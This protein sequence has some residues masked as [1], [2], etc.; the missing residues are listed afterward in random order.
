MVLAPVVSD[1][2]LPAPAA[3]TMLGLVRRNE[4]ASTANFLF[5]MG[6]SC[7]VHPDPGVMRSD[8]AALATKDK[9]SKKGRVDVLGRPIRFKPPCRRAAGLAARPGAHWQRRPRDRVENH[10]KQEHA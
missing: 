2:A 3:S 1:A 8:L 5:V 4:T 9:R 7:E 6:Y 10:R